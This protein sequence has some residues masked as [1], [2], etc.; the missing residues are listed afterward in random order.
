[1]RHL[2]CITCLLSLTLLTP[3]DGRAAG[4]DGGSDGT[5]SS[6]PLAGATPSSR[7][8]S[9]KPLR[10]GVAGSKPFVVRKPGQKPQGLSIDVWTA[11]AHQLRLRWHARVF[12][13]VAEALAAVER[14][15]VDVAVG[16]I[17]ITAARAERVD[18][19]Q[20]YFRSSVGMLVP[21]TQ[22]SIWDHI[23]PFV[24]SAFLIGA[25]TLLLVLLA[26][27]LLVWLAERRKNPEHFP[28]RVLPGV[29]N[30]MWFA[31]VTMTTVGY[32]D[33]APVTSAGRMVA[34]AW[35]LV[36]MVTA[37]SLT[38]AIATALTLSQIDQ[39]GI[40]SIQDLRRRRVAVVRGTP[41]E[42]LARR[43]RA[44]V[45]LIADKEQGIEQVRA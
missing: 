20:P 7:P 8:A 40:S 6:R 13:S 35:M 24:S 44:R 1:M 34:G 45:Q 22:T 16:P 19:T 43:F 9:G 37:S 10:V 26:V 2:V 32:G 15:E 14:G 42:H 36:A 31:L 30:G 38:A 18:F 33:R 25:A 41:G 28:R 5:P 4:D 17:S 29:A 27:G 39:P 21:A 11:A 23:R 12:G 3:G